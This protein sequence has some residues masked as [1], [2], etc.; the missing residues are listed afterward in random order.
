M[1]ATLCS[2]TTLLF[3]YFLVGPI[4]SNRRPSLSHQSAFPIQLARFQCTVV[5]QVEMWNALVT[6]MLTYYHYHQH[7][8]VETTALDERYHPF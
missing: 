8:I 4:Y 2:N 7:S 1:P 6:L 5:R 3:I